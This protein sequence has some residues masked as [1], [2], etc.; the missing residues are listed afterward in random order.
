MLTFYG[1]Q[2]GGRLFLPGASS[3]T[4][5]NNEPRITDLIKILD[6]LIWI[7]YKTLID[8]QKLKEKEDTCIKV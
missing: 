3:G 8:I 7:R 5:N 6:E 4:E 2:G 1:Y